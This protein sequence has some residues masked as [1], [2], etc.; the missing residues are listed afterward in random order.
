MLE[1]ET[2]EA[3]LRSAATGRPEL[4]VLDLG[5]PREDYLRRLKQAGVRPATI[6]DP[7]PF[8]RA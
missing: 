6:P 7:T 5:L 8:D 1:A 3:A 2:A 4:G